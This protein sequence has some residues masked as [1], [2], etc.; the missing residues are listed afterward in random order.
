[1][2]LIWTAAFALAAVGALNLISVA[3]AVLFIGLSVDFGIH[4]ALRYNEAYGQGISST[5]ALQSAAGSVGGAITLTAVAAAIGFFAFLPTDYRG[6]AE[7]G[8]IAGGGMFIALFLNLTLLPAA[9]ALLPP[10]RPPLAPPRSGPPLLARTRRYPILAVSI[11]VVIALG[12]AALVP[13]AKFDFDPLNLKDSTTESASTI[14]ELLDDD[15]ATPYSITVLADNL[16]TADRIAKKLAAVDSVRGTLTLSNFLP[17]DQDPKL[18][19]IEN[20]S[21]LLSSLFT[22]PSKPPSRQSSYAPMALEKFKDRLKIFLEQEKPGDEAL[23]QEIT[24]LQMALTAF[25]KKFGGDEKAWNRLRDNLLSTLPGRLSAL[26][27]GLNAT[28]TVGQKDLPKNILARQLAADGRARLEVYPKGNMRDSDELRRFVSAVREVAPRATGAPVVILEAG[29]TVIAAFLQ[30]ALTAALGIAIL[31][32]VLLRSARD[33]TLVFAPLLLAGLL[34]VAASVIAGLSF[35]FANVIV[36]PL[37]FGLGVAS[38]VH[39]L[40]RERREGDGID[41]LETSTP[42]AVIFSALT[43]IGSF[44]TIAL[45]AHPGTSSMGVLLTIA[46]ISTMASTL[47][48]LPAMMTLWQAT[49]SA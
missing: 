28:V 8:L 15:R 41:V 44:A 29:N 21:F 30:A 9:I 49:R 32:I 7:L 37:L 47:F 35:N 18:E 46:I 38:A 2:G 25:G 24:R 42:R 14:F 1:C 3:F 33:V 13:S 48:V 22:A 10:K 6:L 20:A 39:L 36:L 45:S 4:F 26:K 12:G 40:A 11:A 19:L 31:L 23:K 43:T 16:E 5:A 34:T 27:E 17:K